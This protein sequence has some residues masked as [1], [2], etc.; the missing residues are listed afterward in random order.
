MKAKE[1]MTKNLDSCTQNQTV[2]EA[3]NLMTEKR[4]SVM[5]IVN[6]E[7]TLV[8]IITQ[9]D[10]ISKDVDIPHA[11]VS[12]KLLL[13]EQHKYGNVEEIY[14]RAK[15]RLLSEVMSKNPITVNPETSL[16][17]V[18][19]LMEE[20]NLKRIPVVEDNKLVGMITRKDLLK[21]FSKL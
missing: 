4:H 3:V 14:A 6:E 16:N 19:G 17:S 2:E 1:F 8:G 13:G 21:A 5:P 18:V 15:T 12:I 9:S 20:K 7:D 11:L 10:F